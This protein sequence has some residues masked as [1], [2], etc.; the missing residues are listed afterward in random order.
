L[1]IK[2]WLEQSGT[3]DVKL[4]SDIFTF[5]T[6]DFLE[7]QSSSSKG[8]QR[9]WKRLDNAL[10]IKEQLF[11][12]FTFWKDNY[13]EVLSSDI[14]RQLNTPYSF[15][16]YYLCTIVDSSDKITQG[17]VSSNFVPENHDLITLNRIL[18]KEGIVWNPKSSTKDCWEQL[19]DLA[20]S[21]SDINCK[22]Y[23]ATQFLVDYL[24]LNV[25]R[26]LNNIAFLIDLNTGKYSPAPMFD[27]GRGL[28][29]GELNTYNLPIPKAVEKTR[30][31]PF[32]YKAEKV[33]DVILNDVDI[34]SKFDNKIN[35]TTFEFPRNK[36]KELFKY[37]CKS[38]GIKV[39]EV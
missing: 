15:A 22:E 10:Y 2:D 26:H 9:K 17:C 3:S 31:K 21:V 18:N 34:L 35:I 25:D 6:E 38:V 23:L 39:V 36:S 29:E 1:N 30:L 5:S 8:D 24:L 37:L 33:I 16:D 12:D 27:F 4:Y 13:I 19:C 11:E 32:G 28:L 20:Y 14:L 7:I